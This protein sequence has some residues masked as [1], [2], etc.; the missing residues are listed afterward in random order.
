MEFENDEEVADDGLILIANVGTEQVLLT[1]MYKI[2][3]GS[4]ETKITG[5]N[6]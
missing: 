1:C 3:W 6:N 5:R 4:T 2:H